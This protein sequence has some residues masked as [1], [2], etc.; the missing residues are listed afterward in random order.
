MDKW[1]GIGDFNDAQ[2]WN[3]LLSCA[4]QSVVGLH[5]TYVTFFPH[6]LNICR[7]IIY[8]CNTS[9]VLHIHPIY[10][11]IYIHICTHI[12]IPF[13]VHVY[14]YI[15]TVYTPAFSTWSV[16]IHIYIWLLMCFIYI[17]LPYTNVHRYTPYRRHFHVYSIFY[18]LFI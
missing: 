9:L 15:Y 18:F 2:G 5:Y 12:F 8:I 10:P 3:F 4:S 7:Y 1:L 14:I 17:C 11:I 6:I 16:Y 13:T